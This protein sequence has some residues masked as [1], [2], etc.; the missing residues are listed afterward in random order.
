MDNNIE[1]DKSFD[2]FDQTESEREELASKLSD[3]IIVANIR[4]QLAS[5]ML[6]S[7]LNNNVL[8][9]F[10]ERYDYI[11][12]MYC[13]D[14][15]LI[16]ICKTIRKNIYV[17]IFNEITRRF[18]IGTN[19]D[20][21]SDNEDFYFYVN[22]MY[23]FF[24]INYKTNLINFFK[25]YIYNNKKEIIKQFKNNSEKKDLLFK[26]LKKTFGDS[27]DIHL[28]YNLEEIIRS[29]IELNTSDFEIIFDTI[30]EQD[31]YELN[32]HTINSLILENKFDTYLNGNLFVSE[33]F[34][35]FNNNELKY[36]L[37]ASIRNELFILI[38]EGDE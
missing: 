37:I 9:Y 20:D 38:R 26:S 15:K 30:I 29:Y 7:T 12:R 2:Y 5:P 4:E 8:K 1:Y 3:E 33:F 13:D 11:T 32:L 28:I 35:P 19:L 31:P 6:N 36:E 14:L 25:S 34:K 22:E 10:N 23:I 27:D 24:V 16:Q 21:Y 18:S 17:E